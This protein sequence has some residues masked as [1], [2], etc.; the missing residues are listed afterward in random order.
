[1]LPGFPQD[2]SPEGLA[3]PLKGKEAAADPTVRFGNGRFYVSGIAFNRAGSLLSGQAK[4][5]V[6]F[7]AMYR[8]PGRPDLPPAYEGTYIVDT[9]TSGQFL[10]KPWIE[11]DIPRGNEVC[12]RGYF[13]ATTFT[14]SGTNNQSKVMV[15]ASDDCGK[16][17]GGGNDTWKVSESFAINQSM[18]LA[19]DKRNGDLYGAWRVFGTAN[20]SVPSQILLSKLSRGSKN[21]SKPTVIR[22][23]GLWG[24]TTSMAPDQGTLPT[25]QSPDYRMFRTNMYP[26]M[27]ITGDGVIRIAFSE[28]KGGD[29][30]ADSRIQIATF[31]NNQWSIAALDD[32]AGRGNQ[33]MPAMSCSAN[34]AIV[35]W[36]DQRNDSAP[37]AFPW[38]PL[39]GP[40]IFDVIPP[41]PTHTLDV[42]AA[43]TGSNGN[44][45][46]SIQV[47]RYRIGRVDVGGVEVA[48][49]TEYN[50]VLWPLFG[51]YPFIGDYIDVQPDKKLMPY[52][53]A[54]GVTAFR[55]FGVDPPTAALDPVAVAAQVAA[56]R[57]E[58]PVFHAVWADNR[59]ILPSF[60]PAK[61]LRDPNDPN[62]AETPEAWIKTDTSGNQIE[63]WQAPV[64]G[65]CTP[66]VPTATKNQNVYTATL[67][68][69]LVVGTIDESS[70]ANGLRGYAFFVANTS[71]MPRRFEAKTDNGSFAWQ[72]GQPAQT[73][74]FLDVPPNNV[75]AATVFLSAAISPIPTTTVTVKEVD[76][77]NGAYLA[78]SRSVV[79][80]PLQPGGTAETHNVD[81][82]VHV[83]QIATVANP[84][85]EPQN[86]IFD[87]Q[88]P[89]FDPQNPIFDPQNPIFDPQNPI[90][91]PQNPIFDPQNPIFDPQNPIFEPQNPIFEPQNPIFEPQNPIFEPQNIPTGD[92]VY[93]KEKVTQIAATITN[94]GN[95][96]TG[97]NFDTVLASLPT[98]AVWQLVI[99]RLTAMPATSNESCLRMESRIQSLTNISSTDGQAT[100]SLVLGRGDKA[101]V[102]VRIYHNENEPFI[103]PQNAKDQMAIMVESQAPNDDGIPGSDF[104]GNRPPTA[105]GQTVSTSE[106]MVTPIALQG[107]DP[108]GDALSYSIVNGPN[109]GSVTV[110][111]AQATY[112]PNADFNG[113]DSFTFRVNDGGI[114]SNVA[115]VSISVGAVDDAPVA[116]SQSVATTE[117][118]AVGVVLGA[119]DVDNDPLTFAVVGGPAHG[120]LSGSG[121][122]LTYTPNANF[123]GS[124]SF[125]FT[126]TGAG[127]ESNSAT[128]SITVGAVDDPPTAT[129][130]ALSVLEDMALGLVLG[131]SDVDGSAV[132]FT[133]L[134]APAHG[135]LTGTAPNLTYIPNLN[136]NGADSFSFRASDGTLNSTPAS[137]AITVLPVNDAPVATNDTAGS[138]LSGGSMTIAVLSN[139]S[140]VDDPPTNLSVAAITQAP[141]HGTAVVSGDGKSIIYTTSA[142]FAGADSFAYTARDAAGAISNVATV[143]INTTLNTTGGLLAPYMAPPKKT[144]NLG[145]V[146]PLVW[147][148]KNASGNVIESSWVQPILYVTFTKKTGANEKTCDGG[149][150]TSTVI[151]NEDVPGSS[152]FQY[153]TE[154]NPHTTAGANTW[155][156]NWQLNPPVTAGCWNARIVL[157]LNGNEVPDHN[158]GD[159]VMGPFLYLIK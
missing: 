132:T 16:T 156:F 62:N 119:T 49:Q 4:K 106:D 11:F 58:A 51:L 40:L 10:D 29:A 50:A 127:V 30:S 53:R 24:E 146:A 128:V 72:S 105:S 32:H 110:A 37:R 158:G 21:W 76:L 22:S 84:I 35:V 14:G 147:Q 125:T 112:T 27:C 86:P 115:T 17:W 38:L 36:Y 145:Q 2:A 48:M 80:N 23:L 157:D 81:L 31:R 122:N 82:Q 87:P 131:G 64:A 59:D 79:V 108:D 154:A 139:D 3:S 6:T 46:Q 100:S 13:G 15:H 99:V 1:V 94:G 85:F 26:S 68:E 55:F 102:L 8:D 135:T 97:Y 111:G 121:P 7:V 66:G 33:F 109:N 133:V 47:S 71:T 54:D 124:D 19:L 90:F 43:Q 61:G 129:P 96:A 45:G 152:N 28:R 56:E 120:T 25:E 136:F 57:L 12:G 52:T 9:G 18:N 144:Y 107:D 74:I 114:F 151:V 141:Q 130:Q 103:T 39:W 67:S 140:D 70:A 5:G 123:N 134:S 104:F 98:D 142:A 149:N 34:R 153:F 44:F 83:D 65:T 77:G 159:Q 143:G 126:A 73:S 69:G 113:S 150:E 95:V 117:D 63:N 89:I 75:R 92:T 93:T 148:F 101:V 41:P 138:V 116:A 118:T 42:F 155:Q 78:L 137:V 20:Q 88:N 91:E 60:M